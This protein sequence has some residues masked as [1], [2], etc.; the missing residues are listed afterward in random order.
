MLMKVNQ[1]DDEEI[2]EQ[3]AEKIWAN[4][5]QAIESTLGESL[6]TYPDE[7]KKLY[8]DLMIKI[9]DFKAE[10]DLKNQRDEFLIDRWESDNENRYL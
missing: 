7:I 9:S 1:F 5:N 8:D 3:N 2:I 10:R 4:L 6:D